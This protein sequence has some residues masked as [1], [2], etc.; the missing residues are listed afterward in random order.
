MAID[1]ISTSLPSIRS[2]QAYQQ[3][4]NGGRVDK[5]N[6]PNPG[7][8][9]KAGGFANMLGDALNEVDQLQKD[10]DN[11]IE[12]MMLGKGVKTH[13]AMIALEKAD[14]AFKLMN[15]IRMRITRAYE[16]VMRTQI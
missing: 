2:I 15:N 3:T 11:K 16:E 12:G 10:A 6:N 7:E 14:I 4:Q 8:A 1:S 13:E 9:Q 5:V